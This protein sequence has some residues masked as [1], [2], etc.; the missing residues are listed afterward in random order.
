M[1][2]AYLIMAH[3]RI[4]LLQMLI[5]S[6]DDERNDIIVHIDKKSKMK[7][8]ELSCKNARLVFVDSIDVR[9]GGYSQVECEYLLLKKAKSLGFHLYYHFLTGV[10]YPLWNQD[11]IHEFFKNNNGKEFIGFDNGLDFNERVRFY[12]PFSE[13]GKL[14]G[15]SGKLIDLSRK[16][17]VTFQKLARYNRLGDSDIIIK[18]GCAY[19]SIT[20]KL[21]DEIL[22]NE[23][24]MKK[25][26]KHTVWCD[27]VFVQTV[28]FNSPFKDKIYSLT[29]E[30]EGSMREFAW[31][32]N[33][34]GN[35]PG[36]NFSMQDIDYLLNSKRIFAMKF[37]GDD[38][39]EVIN[40]IKEVK[41]IS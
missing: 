21:V 19:F 40:R 34:P 41:K 18:K 1:K 33:V 29:N 38:G 3:H 26:L 13:H 35:H 20:D 24:L 39:L 17:C 36:W 8:T 30:W 28:A 32:S 2:H 22:K 16:V 37:E 4:D 5:N 14:S 15:I 31:P 7:S 25:M 27:E 11:Y 12:I 6:I 23:P 10:N 9:W